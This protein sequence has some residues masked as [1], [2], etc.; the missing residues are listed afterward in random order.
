MVPLEEA[1]EINPRSTALPPDK[2]VSFV[3]M[4]ELNADRAV[5]EPR[6]TLP[7]RDVAKGYTLFRDQDILAAKITPCWE[8]GKVGQARLDHEDGVGSTEFHVVRVHDSVAARYLMHFLRSPMVRATGE[9]RMTGSGG[10]RRVPANYLRSLEVP[11]PPLVEQQRIA[12]ILD[13]ADSLRAK[14]RQVLAHLDDL[15]Q[16]IFHDMFG[17]FHEW[18]WETS[19]VRD[20]GDVQLGR[21]RAPKYQTGQWSRP[22]LRVAN[23]QMNGLKLDDV[24]TMDFDPRDFAAYRLETGDILLNEGQNTELVGR[25]AMW[26]GEI[27]DCC[28]QNTLVRFRPDRALVT[29][30]FAVHVFLEF[31][32]VGQFARISSKTSNVAHLGKERFAGMDM[33]VPPMGLQ[34]EFSAAVDAIR[35]QQARVRAVAHGEEELFA[36]LQSRAFRGEL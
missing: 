11:L 20:V 5:A 15:T 19:A 10:Q 9:L 24:L 17:R 22:Y 27:D 18:A 36:S 30:E 28:F 4:A 1:A 7:F 13:H 29:P 14:R 12:A 33:P 32:N 25:P 2:P 23:V 6:E 31:L 26:R 8:N 21:Q 34:S 3:G 35:T 16:A